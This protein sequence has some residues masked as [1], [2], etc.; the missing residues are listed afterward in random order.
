MNET[1]TQIVDI[2]DE[3]ESADKSA[4]VADILDMLTQQQRE[5]ILHCL[6]NN[7]PFTQ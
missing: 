4:I 5:H 1:S 7:L 3:F 2:I 6:Q